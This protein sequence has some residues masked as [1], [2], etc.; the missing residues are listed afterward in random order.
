MFWN[1]LFEEAIYGYWLGGYTQI[2][3]QSQYSKLIFW[4][5]FLEGAIYLKFMVAN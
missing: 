5:V 2:L 4:N 1:V 3:F